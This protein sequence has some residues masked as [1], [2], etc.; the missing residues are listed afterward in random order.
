MDFKD[1]IKQIAE[2]IDKV[3]DNLQTEEATDLSIR[4]ICSI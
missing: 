4:N 2:R 3:K 1:S